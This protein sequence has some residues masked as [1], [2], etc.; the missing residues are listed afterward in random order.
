MK[1]TNRGSATPC[2]WSATRRKKSAGVMLAFFLMAATSFAEGRG[3]SGRR[4]FA[5]DLP[6]AGWECTQCHTGNVPDGKTMPEA[7]C[8]SCHEET[9]SILKQTRHGEIFL[10]RF[11]TP[12]GGCLACHGEDPHEIKKISKVDQPK[13]CGNCH[14]NASKVPEFLSQKGP[15]KS[16][17]L[18]V[19]GE[20]VH[21]GNLNAASCSDCHG[22]HNIRPPGDPA[23]TLFHQN[24][25]NTCGQCHPLETSNY[26]SSIH[27]KALAMGIRE[28]PN[29]TDCHGE[30]TI[31][32]P[33]EKSSSVWKGSVTKTCSA[34]HS[35]EKIA[36]KFGLPADRLQTFMDSFHGLAGRAGDLTVANC[37]SCHGWHD[38]LPSSDPLSRTHPDHLS[39]TCGQCH[40]DAGIRLTTEKI[41]PSLSEGASAHP[42]AAWFRSF[43]L[44]LIPLVIG[45]MILFNF[46]DFLRKALTAKAANVY[47]EDAV[48]LSRSE[49]RQHAV[50]VLSFITLAYSGFALA[51]PLSWWAEPFQWL[52]GEVTR[53]NVHRGAA[54]LFVLISFVHLGYVL[55][56]VRGR[57]RLRA[58]LPQKRDLSEPLQLF[59]FNLG[60]LKQRPALKHFSFIE[61]AEYW[62]LVWGSIVM[63]VTG[64][65]L[66]FH[67]FA[68]A[69]FPLWVVEVAQ[70]VH[71]LEA[72]LACL[73]IV[74]WHFYWVMLDPDVYPMN[75]AWLKGKKKL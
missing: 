30:H 33:G 1:K 62:A 63:L 43:Y 52:G 6:H 48:L 14:E 29:C 61:K 55:G 71:F 47:A 21:G 64:L 60:I 11:E 32:I 36:I 10:Q 16:Y 57:E 73:A 37:A 50:L 69:R 59:L 22:G 56:T 54:I 5:E 12:T 34:C 2:K 74:V 8:E 45:G 67:N 68:F 17:L 41:H 58:M 40:P 27:G 25:F 4:P 75:W 28:A 46:I 66:V 26:R 3:P 31:R 20:A 19:H 35:S 39:E 49:R 9:F 38:V 42:I 72:V 51:Y 70:V 7:R 23:S 24:I 65:I 13:I 53:R 44:I 15:V 18:T